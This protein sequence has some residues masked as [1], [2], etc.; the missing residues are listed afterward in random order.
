MGRFN[1]NR[2]KIF[3]V[4]HRAE[5]LKPSPHW[6]NWISITDATQLHHVKTNAAL[7][8]QTTSLCISQDETHVVWIKQWAF[9]LFFFVFFR[10]DFSICT[11]VEVVGAIYSP[12]SKQEEMPGNW[13]ERFCPSFMPGDEVRKKKKSS[14]LRGEIFS[15]IPLSAIWHAF[16]QV[17][18]DRV[19]LQRPHWDI[20]TCAVRILKFW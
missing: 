20:F 7:G 2:L 14:G 1:V 12:Q 17:L 4:V 8:W 19:L 9:F 6:P 11:W 5:T 15:L 10:D 16:H 3:S 18:T 13:L